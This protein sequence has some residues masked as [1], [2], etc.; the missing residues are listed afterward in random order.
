MLLL[1]RSSAVYLLAV[2]AYADASALTLLIIAC[3]CIRRRCRAVFAT[4]F[5]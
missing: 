5:H 4:C 3:L 1:F 2:A